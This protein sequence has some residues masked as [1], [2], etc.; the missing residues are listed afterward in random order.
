MSRVVRA[1]LVWISKEAGGR[2]ALPSGPIY[3]TISRFVEQGARWEDQSWSLI[4][5]FMEGRP[6]SA[7]TVAL[8]QFL[9][10]QAPHELL[11]LGSRF[12][13]LEGRRVV[14]YGEVVGEADSQG[15]DETL[16]PAVVSAAPHD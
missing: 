7:E 16:Q 6:T 12:E 15:D 13:L 10:P 2:Q 3:S 4:V 9:S 5:R 14:A 8:V 11:H 1:R